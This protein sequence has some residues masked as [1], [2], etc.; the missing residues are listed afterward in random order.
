MQTLKTRVREFIMD[1][2]SSLMCI[3][4]AIWLVLPRR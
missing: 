3:G 4:I 2:L 1:T